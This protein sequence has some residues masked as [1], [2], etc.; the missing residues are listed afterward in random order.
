MQVVRTPSMEVGKE[1]VTVQGLSSRVALLTGGLERNVGIGPKRE[2]LLGAGDAVLPRMP[3]FAKCALL[4][5]FSDASGLRR[6]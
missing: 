3:I 5:G 4:R 2:A 6:K 1:P